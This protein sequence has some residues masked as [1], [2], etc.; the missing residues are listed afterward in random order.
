[1]KQR[2]VEFSEDAAAD[3]NSLHDWIAESADPAE[4]LSYIE[5]LEDYCLGFDVAYGRG[6]RRD[7]I[8]PNLRIVGFDRAPGGQP[9]PRRPSAV[10]EKPSAQ[11]SQ[12]RPGAARQAR[13]SE[14]F[15]REREKYRAQSARKPDRAPR[16]K[17][18]PRRPSA[19]REKS[20]GR[21]APASP[22]GRRASSAPLGGLRP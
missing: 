3:P 21:K 10:R 7:K 15:G 19:V 9:A 5:R 12:A 13:P 6:Q 2:L 16:V 18:A 17:R 11:R 20:T 4:A 1:V 8:R 14:A 22:T